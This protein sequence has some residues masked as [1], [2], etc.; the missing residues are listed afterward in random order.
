MIP[1]VTD[2]ETKGTG[3]QDKQTVQS[4]V[5][6]RKTSQYPPPLWPTPI[7][8]PRSGWPLF[9]VHCQ[10]PVWH[11]LGQTQFLKTSE[12]KHEESEEY[13]VALGEAKEH[14]GSTRLRCREIFQKQKDVRSAQLHHGISPWD[15][16]GA[17]SLILKGKIAT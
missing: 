10:V 12:N 1:V 3:L 17:S 16:A 4:N 8:L 9:S 15:R 2:E 11:L 13:S 6:H 14:A 7:C 5:C